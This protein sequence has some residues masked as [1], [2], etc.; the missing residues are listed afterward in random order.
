MSSLIKTFYNNHI[1][2]ECKKDNIKLMNTDTHEVRF[3]K[4][5]TKYSTEYNNSL[6][7]Q[8]LCQKLGFDRKDTIYYFK[9][10]QKKYSENEIFD[11]FY[12]ERYS[13][14]EK[15]KQY[16]LDNLRNELIILEA[17]QRFMNDVIYDNIVIYKRKKIEIIQDLFKMQV[18]RV[19]NGRVLHEIST[20]LNEN[21]SNY[22]YLI[23]MSLYLFTEDEIE[24]LEKQINK[25]HSEYSELEKKTIEGIWISEC[26]KLLDYL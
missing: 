13:L 2:H 23:K 10:L 19:I 20:E 1:F 24:K 8:N 6:F 26:D 11:E 5:L 21:T 16:Q 12:E 9:D 14:Y 4:V 15:R 18:P 7:I 22:D 3:T 17:K 25:I